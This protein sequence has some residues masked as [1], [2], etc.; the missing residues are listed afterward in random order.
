VLPFWLSIGALGVV[1]GL[2]VAAPRPPLPLPLLERLRTRWW[3]LLPP[4]SI[5]VVIGAIALDSASADVLTYLALIAVPPLAAVAAGGLAR[6]GRPPL[7]LAVIPLFA[8]AWAAR[9]E[10]GGDA[11][12]VALTGLACVSLGWLLASVVPAAWLKIGIY[13]MAAID[14]WLVASNL[15]QGPNAVLNTASP[16]SLPRLQ[17]AH[18]G[19][20]LM[21]FGDLFLAATLG[22]VLAHD[23]RL[24]R[25]GAILTAAIAIAFDFLFFAVDQLPATVPVALALTVLEIS[26]RRRLRAA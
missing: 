3:A 22:A 5:V 25:R 15:L 14:T 20:A 6:G 4:L 13:A 26:R 9:G 19:S 16:G 17:L 2:L 23:R 1:Q 7:A 12:A 11:A 10:L 21:G 8:L 18:F 24:Q